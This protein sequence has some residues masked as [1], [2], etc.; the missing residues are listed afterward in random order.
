MLILPNNELF[1]VA[2]MSPVWSRKPTPYSKAKKII[3]SR[4]AFDV[5]FPIYPEIDMYES[6]WIMILGRANSIRGVSNISLGTESG[7]VADPKKIFQH[8]LLG[9]A[10]SI[11]CFHNHPSGNLNPSSQ[12]IQI[13]K[14]IQESGRFLDLPMIDHLILSPE[15]N[16]FSFADEG[17]L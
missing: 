1:S 9:K 10:S 5:L 15:G 13:T 8:A 12:D 16:Y 6:F 4:D 11:I 17:M 3:S 2:E 7:T 14:K